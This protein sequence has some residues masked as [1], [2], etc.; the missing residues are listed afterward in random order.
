MT[1]NATEQLAD[2]AYCDA[3][4]RRG[5]NDFEVSGI[6]VLI[7]LDSMLENALRDGLPSQWFVA[8]HQ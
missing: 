5:G 7:G 4:R 6:S 8:T 3:S 2:R 1:F